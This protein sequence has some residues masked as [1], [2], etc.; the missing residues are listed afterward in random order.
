MIKILKILLIGII[1]FSMIT[2]LSIL[3]A[4]VKAWER[5]LHFDIWVAL[6]IASKFGLYGAMVI[7]TIVSLAK[8]NRGPNK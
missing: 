2:V 8:F 4:I 6:P 5:G 3:L 1:I 7:M